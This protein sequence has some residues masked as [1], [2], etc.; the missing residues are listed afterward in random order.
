MEKE[1]SE[2]PLR[3]LRG[4][5]DREFRSAFLG[6]HDPVGAEHPIHNAAATERFVEVSRKAQGLPARVTDLSVITK[7]AGL[8][9]ADPP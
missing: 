2:T 7:V 1:T 8:L 5:S 6:V 4:S 3:P 9:K